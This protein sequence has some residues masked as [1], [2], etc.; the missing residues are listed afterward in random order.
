MFDV[1]YTL[2]ASPLAILSFC[3]VPG[4]GGVPILS[5]TTPLYGTMLHSLGLLLL[6]IPG[7]FR[8]TMSNLS[9]LH[10]RYLQYRG[11]CRTYCLIY[12]A[13]AIMLIF[14]VYSFFLVIL[15][16]L[17]FN[18]FFKINIRSIFQIYY[19]FFAHSVYAFIVF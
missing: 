12:Y 9:S 7:N 18:C 4:G 3:S 13:M 11:L 8:I 1:Y 19:I 16:T 15:S 6:M 2:Y 10:G 17:T 14:Q 5:V